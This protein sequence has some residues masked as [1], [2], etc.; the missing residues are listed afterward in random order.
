M[1]HKWNFIEIRRSEAE[2]NKQ[3]KKLIMKTVWINCQT[4]PNNIL[5]FSRSASHF[6]AIESTSNFS[7][8]ISLGDLRFC[9]SCLRINSHHPLTYCNIF[10]CPTSW[11]RK[12]HFYGR[13]EDFLVKLGDEMLG[14]CMVSD[15]VP[16][17]RPSSAFC[18]AAGS[19]NG[20][21]NFH[22]SSFRFSWFSFNLLFFQSN[23]FCLFFRL[24]F[25]SRVESDKVSF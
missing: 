10:Y 15:F 2:E 9:G 24:Q 16:F 25:R 13:L 1:I 8:Q 12:L 21:I 22:S 23:V 20:S 7:K 19:W 14:R 18:F 5:L 4:P 3:E 17:V 11:K 6:S